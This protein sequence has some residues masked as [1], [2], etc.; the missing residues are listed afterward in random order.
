[1]VKSVLQSLLGVT[2]ETNIPSLINLSQLFFPGVDYI[3][4]FSLTPDEGACLNPNCITKYLSL[5]NG[6]TVLQ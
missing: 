5:N 4:L 3:T 2:L 1:M 6:V